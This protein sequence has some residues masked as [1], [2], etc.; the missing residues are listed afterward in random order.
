MLPNLGVGGCEAIEDAAVLAEELSTS[1]RID[2]ALEA[3]G[4][5]R[6]ERAAMFA[7]RSRQL[8]RIAHLHNPL[9]VGLRNAVL[10]TAPPAAFLGRSPIT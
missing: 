9:A 1:S 3:Y 5:R 2:L 8:A 6:A 7:R 10:R 4:R